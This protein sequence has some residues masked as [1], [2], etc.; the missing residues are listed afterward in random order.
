M[1][2]NARL[3]I[4]EC[5]TQKYSPEMESGKSVSRKMKSYINRK[6]K[7]KKFS[8]RF[9]ARRMFSTRTTHSHQFG[10]GVRS[11]CSLDERASN[12]NKGG[13]LSPIKSVSARDLSID[14]YV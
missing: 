14:Y 10:A 11:K 3:H 8:L 1:S 12:N 13:V 6:N 9:M 4:S 2:K 5:G 7:M